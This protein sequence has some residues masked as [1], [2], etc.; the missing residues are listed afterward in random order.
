MIIIGSDAFVFWYKNYMRYLC[1]KIVKIG[2]VFNFKK[3]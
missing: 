2:S 1:I 3:A